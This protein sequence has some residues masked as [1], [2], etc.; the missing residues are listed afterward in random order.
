MSRD[1]V[2]KQPAPAS[3]Q[4]Y[5]ERERLRRAGRWLAGALANREKRNRREKKRK[6]QP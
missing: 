4:D 5:Y 2:K 1:P 3:P 6:G